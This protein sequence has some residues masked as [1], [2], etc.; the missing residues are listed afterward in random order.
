MRTDARAVLCSKIFNRRGLGQF[1]P[2][3]AT[4][5]TGAVRMRKIV[6]IISVLTLACGLLLGVGCAFRT[7]G[8]QPVTITIWHVYGGQTDSPLNDLIEVFNNTVGVEE[9]IQV[10]VTMVSD[11]KN[12][13]NGVIAAAV[14]EPGAPKLPDMFVSY[15]KTVL[16]LPDQN[17]LVDYRDY[18]TEEELGAFVPSFLEDGEVRGRLVCLPVAKSTELL[19]VNKTDFDRFSA[20]TGV[21]IDSLRTWEG[22][23]DTCCAYEEWTDSLTPDIMNDGKAFFVHDYHFDYFQVGVESLGT[24]F[25]DGDGISFSSTFARVW[26]PYA[27]AAISGG[28]WL[29]GGYATDPLRTGEAVASVGSSASVLYYTNEVIHADNTTE[30]I[31]FDILPCPTFADGEKLVMQRG[32]GICTVKST[33]EKEQA[34]VRFLKWLT[35]PERNVQFAVSTGYMPVVQTAY[36]TYLP[37]CIGRLTDQKYVELYRAYAETQRD[38][39]FYRAP[40]TDSYLRLEDAFESNV[41]KHLTAVRNSFIDSEYKSDVMLERLVADSYEQFKQGF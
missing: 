24:S 2:L 17:I 32:A 6:G 29:E 20:A 38:Y 8:N 39:T 40:Q 41:R 34:A 4:V 14:G 35:E 22:L 33:P 36:D 28:L 10:E 30:S 12:I 26:Q 1:P 31:E 16:A 13:H 9:G 19:F 37:Q 27:R 25:F 3:Q 21:T 11:N 15:P 7:Q 23:F 18:L 5:R